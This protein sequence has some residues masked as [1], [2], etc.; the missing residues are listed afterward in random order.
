LGARLRAS[1]YTPLTAVNVMRLMAHL[2]RWLSANGLGAADL[3]RGQVERYV[4][5]RRAEGRTSGLSPRSLDP[6]LGMLT[7]AGALT[8][9][10]PAGPVS[11]EERLLA[12]FERHLL[13]ERALTGSTAAAYVAYARRFLAGRAGR[14]LDGATAADITGAVL[15]EAEAVSAS[16]AQYFVVALRAFLRFCFLDGLVEADLAGAALAVTG[17][18]RLPL[19][20][21]ISRADA[22]EL[23]ASCDR[24]RAPPR[25]YAVL[26]LLLRLGLRAS[27]AATL[28]LEDIDWRAGEITVHGKGR[29]DER[30][31]LPADVGEAIAGYLTR[32]RPV[33]GQREVFLRAVAPAGP[34]SRGGI[35]FIVRRACRRAGVAEVG[36]HR[37]RHTAACEMAAAGA[38]LTEI[39]QV[40]R[41]QILDSTANYAR[42]GVAVL[43]KLARPWPGGAA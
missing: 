26:M 17:R 21:G 29:R 40:L 5:A 15:A 12:A 36:A 41:H 1:G 18:R 27:E 6:I 4:A 34:L 19:P 39:G 25:D 7:D 31:P 38:P 30:L 32:G 13:C 9:E 11:E 20:R 3:T 24:R 23:L 37:L 14:R 42:V 28:T 33:T 10:E 43:R 22:R 35:S 8:P 2:S 16:S